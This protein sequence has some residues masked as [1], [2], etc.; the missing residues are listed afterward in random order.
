MRLDDDL[1]ETIRLANLY[2]GLIRIGLEPQ[3]N[4]VHRDFVAWADVVDSRL[5]YEVYEVLTGRYRD[6]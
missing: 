2:N 1:Q 4:H 3:A 5:V 6:D